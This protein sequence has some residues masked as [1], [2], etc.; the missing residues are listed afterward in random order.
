M[1]SNTTVPGAGP[2]E[3]TVN[4]NGAWVYFGNLQTCKTSTLSGESGT[5]KV[6]YHHDLDT[7]YD[8]RQSWKNSLPHSGIETVQAIGYTK[9]VSNIVLQTYYHT[10][11]ENAKLYQEEEVFIYTSD[12]APFI[13]VHVKYKDLPYIFGYGNHSYQLD[14]C[15]YI[16]DISDERT[17]ILQYITDQYDYLACERDL[18]ALGYFTIMGGVQFVND[19]EVGNLLIHFIDDHQGGKYQIYI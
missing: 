16:E 8:A 17:A 2:S 3:Y 11:E 7:L 4:E 19:P 9:G 18:K 1:L 15:T 10:R 13:S 5:A 6:T 14:I 12:D